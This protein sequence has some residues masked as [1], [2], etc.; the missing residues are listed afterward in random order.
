[1]GKW[2]AK[3]VADG[4]LSTWALRKEFGNAFPRLGSTRA[5]A[6][7]CRRCSFRYPVPGVGIVAASN[8]LFLI[9]SQDAPQRRSKRA[10][11]GRLEAE[12]RARAHRARLCGPTTPAHPPASA[13]HP[14]RPSASATHAVEIILS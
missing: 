8:H 13:Q 10:F 5:T 12:A 11:Q 14:P 3:C 9:V 2:R 4:E 7:K 6:F 1:M